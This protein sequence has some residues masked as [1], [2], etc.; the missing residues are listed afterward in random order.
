[1]T[2][3]LVSWFLCVFSHFWFFVFNVEIVSYYVLLCCPRGVIC[4]CTHT[5]MLCSRRGGVHLHPHS[6]GEDPAKSGISLRSTTLAPMGNN[7]LS[8]IGQGSS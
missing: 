1:M 2:D 7:G 5:S 6:L 3:N 4:V 8:S